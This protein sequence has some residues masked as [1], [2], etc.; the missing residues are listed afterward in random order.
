VVSEVAERVLYRDIVPYDVPSSLDA[1]GGPVTGVLELPVTVHWGPQRVYDLATSHE[2]VFAYQQI[3]REG[4]TAD[5][6]RLLNRDL[7]VRVWS[8]LILPPRCQRLWETRFCE[9]A[10]VR[11]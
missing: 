11:Q 9:L 5:Q 3:V 4:T 7:L 1:L 10:T 2:M 6:E 8:E